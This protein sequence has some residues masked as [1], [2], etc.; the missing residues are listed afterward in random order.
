MGVEDRAREAEHLLGHDDLPARTVA[1]RLDLVHE[2]VVA[3]AVLDDQLGLAD[4]DRHSGAGFE[5]VGVRV[6]VAH[7]GAHADIRA[8]YL[9]DHVRVLVLGA[10]GDD[11]GRNGL[12]CDDLG[13]ADLAGAEL[14]GAEPAAAEPAAA[15]PV[16]PG[17]ACPELA[18]A[19]AHPAS[20]AAVTTTAMRLIKHGR[21]EP[22]LATG[23][24]SMPIFYP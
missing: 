10:N 16:G 21:A 8:A 1:R 11:L 9:R 22:C 13:C 4:L 18:D 20:E 23:A 12:G 5:L 14:A 2:A 15:E 17:P 6:R 7:Y 3:D 19:D 24:R